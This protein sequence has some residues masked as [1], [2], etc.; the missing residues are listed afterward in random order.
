MNK[1]NM[2]EDLE[3]IDISNNDVIEELKIDEANINVPKSKINIDGDINGK[4]EGDDTNNNQF[5]PE[6]SNQNSNNSNYHNEGYSPD[7]IPRNSTSGENTNVNNSDNNVP[8][9]LNNKQN[10]SNN[11]PVSQNGVPENNTLNN[12][13]KDNRSL[14]Q[15]AKDTKDKIKDTKDKIKNTKDKIKNAPENIK[16]KVDDTKKKFDN[17]KDKVKNVP[18]NLRKKREQVKNTWNNRP[19]SMKEAK[20]KAKNSLKSKGANLKNKAKNGIKNGAS[21]A[22]QKT[23]EEIKKG[24][25][26]A[27]D[28][29]KVGQAYNT[30]KDIIAFIKK[31]KNIKKVVTVIGIAAI[32][33]GAIMLFGL[34]VSVVAVFIPGVIG[35]ANNSYNF[36]QYSEIDQKTLVDLKDVYSK[37]PTADATLAITT[38]LYPYFS[39]LHGGNVTIYLSGTSGYNKTQESTSTD[40]SGKIVRE[41]S[42]DMYLVLF[43]NSDVIKRLEKL[44]QNM[45]T[46]GDTSVFEQYLKNT[47]FASDSGISSGYDKNIY[48]GYNGYKHMF[49]SLKKSSDTENLKN[50]IIEDLYGIK[51][52]FTNYIFEN[53][54]CSTTLIDAGTVTVDEMLNGTILV[55]PKVDSCTSG[56]A[57]GIAACESW[58]PNP[59]TLEEYIKGVVWIE[60]RPST[61]T[62][63]EK[64]KAQMV[65]AKSYVLNRYKSMGWDLKK[66]ESGEYVLPIRSNTNDQDY[67][68]YTVGC[69]GKRSGNNP[70][71]ANE[72]EKQMLQQAW[73]AISDIYIYNAK[74]NSTAGSYCASRVKTDNYDCSWCTKGN[75][76]SQTELNSLEDNLTLT[77]ETILKDQYS[78]YD[79]VVIENNSAVLK[80]PGALVCVNEGSNLDSKRNKVMSSA[81]SYSGKIP[82]YEGGIAT[83]KEFDE[84]DFGSD[85]SDDGYG[86]VKKGLNSVGFVN[87]VYWNTMDNNF[88]NENNI[89]N[90]INDN[91]TYEIKKEELLVGDLG[92]SDDKTVIG[93]YLGNET[94]AYE[95]SV[96]GNVV[97]VPTDIFTKYRRLNELKEEIYEFT[98]RENAPTPSEWKDMDGYYD[99]GNTGECAW[100][101][102]NRAVEIINELY[103]NGSL[104]KVQYNNYKKRISNSRGNGNQ[105][106]LNGTIGQYIKRG[107]N[108]INDYKSG[109]FMGMNSSSKYGHVVVVEYANKQEDKIIITHGWNSGGTCS[110]T[111]YGCFAFRHQTYTY[112]EFVKT[113]VNGDRYNFLGYLYFLED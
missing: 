1:K 19:K 82:Y 47:Y 78:N 59:I 16:N 84:N 68:D 21:K 14:S 53:V 73:D 79:L 10:S 2:N 65:A 35:D 81:I 93:I 63:I 94:W 55:D 5:K 51:Y 34:I 44:M 3:L 27:F 109:V 32:V 8:N 76:L 71:A 33:F 48:N 29:S 9:N 39:N 83:S 108:N 7:S 13:P 52:M 50:A 107:S 11:S 113:F 43:R 64:V 61:S 104:T 28:N 60:M 70:P 26:T 25:K 99:T 58:H 106:Y 46:T 72:D 92:Y 17:A 12:V 24:A 67:C 96:S 23:K 41:E 88:G 22:K 30:A 77:V 80:T 31:I 103:A 36:S 54:N 20:E 97:N 49:N 112:N 66:T 95:D 75:C 15:K 40:N 110:K 56:S 85:V 4:I 45:G 62:N 6:I 91:V 111:N 86:R 87:F 69:T 105:F 98:I 37:Y 89:N 42:D 102:K 101:A 90:I 57:S 18:E 38:V 100:Y 74:T